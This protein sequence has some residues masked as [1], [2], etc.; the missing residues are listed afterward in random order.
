MVDISM[1]HL[2]SFAVASRKYRPVAVRILFI[3]EAPPAY[4]S[5]RFFYFTGLQQA[6]TLFLEMMKTLYPLEVGYS[7]N[8][9]REGF[10]S[11]TIRLRK[12]ELLKRFKSD[13]FYL[14][15]ACERP[16]PDGAN[17][18]LKSALMQSVLPALKAKV[19]RLCSAETVGILLIGTVTYHVCADALRGE[20]VHVL[21]K[22]AINHPARGG[23][24]LFRAKLR[25]A[26]N[27]LP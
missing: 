8:R 3:A 2:N 12:G 27:T 15:D 13:G 14:V 18:A 25:A 16:M 19:R 9:F 6:D 10:S 7:E 20:G 26:L 22:I 4:E 23:Q 24:I 21:N 11:A 17:T 1:R 5:K